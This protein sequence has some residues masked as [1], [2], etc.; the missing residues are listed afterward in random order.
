[1]PLPTLLARERERFSFGVR[2]FLSFGKTDKTEA[3][4]EMGSVF[5]MQS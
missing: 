5:T 3:S 1:M 4:H 2:P